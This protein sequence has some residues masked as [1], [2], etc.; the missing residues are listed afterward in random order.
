MHTYLSF[1]Y[2]LAIRNSYLYT[3]YCYNYC[4]I[5]K[6]MKKNLLDNSLFYSTFKSHDIKF[7]HN[8]VNIYI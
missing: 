6:S 7:N 1:K 5:Y 4:Y 8:F 3:N 2:L